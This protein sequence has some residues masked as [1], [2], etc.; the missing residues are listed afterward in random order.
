ML[1]RD[2][3]PYYWDQPMVFQAY[4]EQQ[5]RLETLAG[6]YTGRL[7]WGSFLIDGRASAIMARAGGYITDDLAYFVPV[8]MTDK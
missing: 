6:E 7:L 4:Q 1:E 2:R 5:V 3:E 8:G